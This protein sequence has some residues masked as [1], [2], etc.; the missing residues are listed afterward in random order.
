M[1]KHEI[2]LRAVLKGYDM[3]SADI[4]EHFIDPQT[5]KIPILENIA[6][7]DIKPHLVP[8]PR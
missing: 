2:A 5:Q 8:M 7:C 3:V 6:C 4:A 1:A